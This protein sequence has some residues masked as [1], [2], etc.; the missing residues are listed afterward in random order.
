MFIYLITNQTYNPAGVSTFLSD[1]SQ[2]KIQ[3][4][5]ASLG[6]FSDL[7]CT[8][9]DGYFAW[10]F[11]KAWLRQILKSSSFYK[12]YAFECV[13]SGTT[14]AMWRSWVEMRTTTPPPTTTT[15]TPLVILPGGALPVAPVIIPY[16]S[17][18]EE[19]EEHLEESVSSFE[20][21]SIMN[22]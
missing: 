10:S 5:S 13:R 16:Q 17:D 21:M 2:T 4:Y 8:D 11:V 6:D 7:N 3:Q 19:T 22:L 9:K 14:P 12:D 1:F 20:S 15:A 18:Y